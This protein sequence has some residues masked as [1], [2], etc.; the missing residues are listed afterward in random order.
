[1]LARLSGLPRLNR[2]NIFAWLLLVWAGIYLPGLGTLEFQGEE[3]RRV[4]PAM[5]MMETGNWVVPYVG[6]EPYY[7]KPPLVNWLVAASFNLTGSQSEFTARLPSVLFVLVFVAAVV[8]LP[9]P[10]L[11][12]SGRLI[13]AIAFMTNISLLEKGRLIELEALYTC[14]TGLA[15]VW[16]LD[17]YSR[18]GSRWWLWLGPAIWLAMGALLKGPLQFLYFYG[19][20]LV[21]LAR[22]RQ[23]RLLLSWPHALSLVVSVGAFAGWAHLASLQSPSGA[24]VS[25]WSNE[26]VGHSVG[27]TIQ[28]GEWGDSIYKAFRNFLPWLALAP[29]LWREAWVQRIPAPWQPLF[30]AGRL[31]LAVLFLGTVLLPSSHPRYSLPLFPLA[32]L[33]LGL[34]LAHQELAGPGRRIGRWAFLSLAALAAAAGVVAMVI[35]GFSGF[36]LAA[37]LL[38][39]GLAV[40]WLCRPEWFDD[41][42]RLACA[43]AV[44]ACAGMFA[45]AAFGMPV[46]QRRS[47]QRTAA[48]TLM[49][50][51]PAGETLYV[52]C[53]GCLPSLFYVRAPIKYV[54]KPGDVDGKVHYL[55]VAQKRLEDLVRHPQVASRQPQSILKVDNRRIE[56]FE[57]LRLGW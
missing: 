4:L 14:L 13:A 16:W 25:T 10:W 39:A 45:F 23:T 8:W 55:L 27:G 49:Q 31:A 47:H 48:R 52:F 2:A 34:L 32:C 29:W 11:P 46:M 18:N 5:T 6:G 53:P 20:V 44:L 21:V 43:G 24:M 9:L 51:L 26:V 1:M 22:D 19:L 30:R 57:L 28:W 7:K 38:L 15:M 12:L 42:P 3:T 56:K 37:V 36:K 50:A 40:W 54:L 35:L 17:G 41:W 33:L